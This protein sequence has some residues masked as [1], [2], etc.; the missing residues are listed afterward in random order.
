MCFYSLVDN[1]VTSGYNS[2]EKLIQKI[3]TKN[4]QEDATQTLIG[5]EL[6]TPAF[7]NV[8]DG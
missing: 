2:Q 3:N 4:Y 5:G 1:C 7:S 6:K 8:S